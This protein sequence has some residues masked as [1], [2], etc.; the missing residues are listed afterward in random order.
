MFMS[1]LFLAAMTFAFAHQPAGTA[2]V[3]S[4]SFKAPAQLTLH[5]PV[6]AE[7]AIDNPA[8][9][10]VV[11]DLGLGRTQF[12]TVTVTLPDG[13][14][15]SPRLGLRDGLHRLGKTEI[16][17]KSRYTQQLLLT[18]WLAFDTPGVYQIE[19]GLALPKGVPVQSALAAPL[20]ATRFELTIGPRDANV[21]RARC[22]ALASIM[23]VSQNAEER[24]NAGRALTSMI[25]E[26]VVP[27]LKRASA[28]TNEFDHVIMRSLNR[29][30][31]PAAEALL[32]EMATSDDE[33]R[34]T[35]ARSYLTGLVKR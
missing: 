11:I 35:M 24:I 18:E 15:V 31:Q 14:V 7:L 20:A 3:L 22:G 25:D 26:A 16:P 8:E 29:M 34:A 32:Q 6:L 19:L 1:H 23:A 4:V 27:C 30:N 5:E 28:S 2:D 33:D 9:R 12:I 13:S 10:P 17:A 21:L